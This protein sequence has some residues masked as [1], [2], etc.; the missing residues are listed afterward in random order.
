MYLSRYIKLNLIIVVTE[1][2][3][4][5]KVC[6]VYASTLYLLRRL[7]HTEKIK[8][9]SLKYFNIDWSVYFYDTSTKSRDEQ[10]ASL[11]LSDTPNHR[12]A[13]QLRD[14]NLKI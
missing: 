10:V 11:M 4:Q 6:L 3:C 2:V 9:L 7:K 5:Q 1:K 13:V 8:H 12:V 14:L